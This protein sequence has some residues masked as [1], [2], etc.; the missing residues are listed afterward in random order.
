M[1]AANMAGGTPHL[2]RTYRSPKNEL[3]ECQIVRA[4]RATTAAPTF[5][6]R[7]YLEDGDSGA[8]YIDGGMG[9]NNPI[10]WVL[11]EAANL[12]PNKNIASIVSIGCGHP[13]TIAILKR[14]MFTRVLLLDVIQALRQIATDCEKKAQDMGRK[15]VNV[16]D[17]YF[18][19]SV[20]QGLQGVDLA[21]WERLQDVEG[22]TQTYMLAPEVDSALGRAVEA[23]R[24]RTGRVPAA[25]ASTKPNRIRDV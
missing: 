18:R 19:F 12:S 20:D 2:I 3:P 8:A 1:A 11:A 14:N 4:I 7:A 15:F 23:I 17:F 9:C 21:D 22:V 24:S 6:K 10:E 25:H 5:F 13:G 16:E